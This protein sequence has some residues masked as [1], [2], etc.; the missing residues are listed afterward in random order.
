MSGVAA[1]T[2]VVFDVDGTLTDSVEVDAECYIAALGEALGLHLDSTDWSRF[3]DCSDAGIAADLFA[4]ARGR[5]IEPDELTAFHDC[6]VE[7]LQRALVRTPCAEIAGAAE[8]LRQL[9]ADARFELCIATGG[10]ERSA[11]M[12]LAAAGIDVAGV[13]LASSNDARNRGDI[14][15]EAVRRAIRLSAGEAFSTC[16]SVGDGAWDAKTAAA[17]GIPFIGVARR[18]PGARLRDLGA[19]L[20]V[21]DLRD[22]DA[23]VA[24]IAGLDACFPVGLVT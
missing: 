22:G 8:L 11:R 12:K 20:V 3:A 1:R 19:T 6:F 4:V 10:W 14:V 16:V 18:A 15:R 7:R 13:A 24:A 2:L 17:L 9:H 5:R 23:F 21:E